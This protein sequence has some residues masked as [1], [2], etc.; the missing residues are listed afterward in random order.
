MSLYFRAFTE[1]TYQAPPM[2]S[3][4]Q[5]LSSYPYSGFKESQF[6]SLSFGQAVASMY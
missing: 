2:I 6:Y 5:V 4:G 3:D 1:Y